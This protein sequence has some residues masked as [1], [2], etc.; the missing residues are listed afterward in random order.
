MHRAMKA[1]Q[2]IAFADSLRIYARSA[3]Y[4][5]NEASLFVHELLLRAYARMPT[6]MPPFIAEAASHRIDGPNARG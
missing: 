3:G 6:N 4:D 2:L 1:D 5:V